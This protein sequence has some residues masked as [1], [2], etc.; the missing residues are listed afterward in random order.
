MRVKLQKQDIDLV[1]DHLASEQGVIYYNEFCK[2]TEEKRRNIDPYDHSPT[3]TDHS[4][5]LNF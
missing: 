2:L 4:G 5:N 3:K 1:F